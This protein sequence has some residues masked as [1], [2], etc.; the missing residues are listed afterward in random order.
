[1][2][3]V[4]KICL[5][6]RVTASALINTLPD[7]KRESIH[8]ETST[9]MNNMADEEMDRLTLKQTTTSVRTGS[10]KKKSAAHRQTVWRKK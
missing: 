3:W 4:G 2:C 5:A 1:M 7:D 8:S 10:K 9:Y 6:C